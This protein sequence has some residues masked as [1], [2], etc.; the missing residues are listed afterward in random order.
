MR[1]RERKNGERER[2][3]VTILHFLPRGV[4]IL[5]RS[6]PVF[7]NQTSLVRNP[8][9]FNHTRRLRVHVQSSAR[10]STCLYT[11]PSHSAR[12]CLYSRPRSLN[13]TSHLILS[14]RSPSIWFICLGA[15]RVSRCRRHH[16][17]FG[18]AIE[19]RPVCHSSHL[20]FSNIH[21]SK[22]YRGIGPPMPMSCH[23][24]I[25]CQIAGVCSNLQHVGWGTI[26]IHLCHSILSFKNSFQRKSPET[27]VLARSPTL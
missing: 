21:P 13:A 25:P 8:N 27:L 26:P 10:H 24:R 2:L 14:S 11:K 3:C 19:N 5:T 1:E 4:V 22:F 12:P 7:T 23:L 6:R 17:S 18:H 16:N 15:I 20:D 9:L